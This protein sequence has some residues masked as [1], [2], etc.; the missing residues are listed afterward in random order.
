L[1]FT[2]V[3][4]AVF[5]T[6]AGDPPETNWPIAYELG[7]VDN[8]VLFSWTQDLFNGVAYDW[9]FSPQVYFF[10]EIPISCLAYLLAGGNLQIYYLVVAGLNNA[11]LFLALAWTT[12]W[13][14]P[15]QTLRLVL[16]RAATASLPLVIFPLLTHPATPQFLFHLAPNYYYGIYLASFLVPVALASPKRWQK[17]LVALIYLATAACDPLLIALSAPALVLAAFCLWRRKRELPLARSI[18]SWT[19][20]LVLVAGLIYIFAFRHSGIAADSITNGYAFSTKRALGALGSIG[21]VLLDLALT[22]PLLEVMVLAAWFGLIWLWRKLSRTTSIDS[23]PPPPPCLRQIPSRCAVL[24]ILPSLVWVRRF[25]D[26]LCRPLLV[27]L[28]DL[29]RFSCGSFAGATQR[30][31]GATC[32][33]YRL[34][35]AKHI[36]D[37]TSRIFF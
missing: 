7:Y 3:T 35:T 21:K 13:L 14:Y 9:H 15:E 5:L 37:S 34:R 4:L 17:L 33:G 18:V 36:P 10:P 26:Y 27:L 20:G 29:G 6:R 32:S 12:R 24:P 25:I 11:F 1:I 16:L 2:A 30:S 28:A 22:A 19:L 23:T 31:S 8:S